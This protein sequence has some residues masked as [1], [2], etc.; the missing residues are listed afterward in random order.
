[1]QFIQKI[2]TNFF[3]VYFV[4]VIIALKGGIIM[5]IG[6]FITKLLP[7]FTSLFIIALPL[8]ADIALENTSLISSECSIITKLAIYLIIYILF[9]LLIIAV[10]LHIPRGKKDKFNICL[11][12]VTNDISDDAQI[13]KHNIVT[14]FEKFAQNNNSL[15]VTVPNIFCRYFFNYWCFNNPF[16]SSKSN[17][18]LKL[19]TTISRADLIVFGQLEPIMSSGI[20]CKQIHINT[21]LSTNKKG[22]ND[23]RKDINTI[24]NK[25]EIF[26]NIENEREGLQQISDFIISVTKVYMN[27]FCY[28]INKTPEG[29]KRILSNINSHYIDLASQGEESIK[30][31]YQQIIRYYIVELSYSNSFNQETVDLMIDTCNNYLRLFGNDSD[32]VLTQQFFSFNKLRAN[33]SS[34]DDY[35]KSISNMLFCLNN[36]SILDKNNIS[37]IANKAYLNLIN[38]NYELAMKLF[39]ELFSRYPNKESRNTFMELFKYYRDVEIWSCEYEYAQF[40]YAYYNLKANNAPSANSIAKRIFEWLTKNATDEFI[41]I[42]SNNYLKEMSN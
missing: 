4:C 7:H 22:I 17:L 16:L 33:H 28:N 27:F 15:F 29:I 3:D 37:I 10:S 31:A 8:S 2:L 26:Y 1:M 42:T 21:Y 24:L 38:H 6:K 20:N 9:L 19:L 5:E 32:I 25:T 40:A 23:N 36:I 18:A 13:V 12:I 35:R 14:N 34:I 39:D 30:K 11:I 41:F